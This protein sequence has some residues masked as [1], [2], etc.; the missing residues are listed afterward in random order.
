MA[1]PADLWGRVDGELQLGL[2]AVVHREP[3]HQQGGETRPSAAA[4]RVKDEEALRIKKSN[5]TNYALNDSDQ[6]A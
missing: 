2:L 1:T 3:L 5:S 6:P 4:K